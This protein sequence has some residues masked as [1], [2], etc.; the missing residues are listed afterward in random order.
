MLQKAET[1]SVGKLT[2]ENIVVHHRT[3]D[4]IHSKENPNRDT[5]IILNVAEAMGSLEKEFLNSQI[6][7]CRYHPGRVEVIR[8]TNIIR[9]HDHSIL[10]GRLLPAQ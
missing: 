5:D 8:L 6:Y 9:Q 2:Q 7:M 3:N 1:K 10:Y 4:I